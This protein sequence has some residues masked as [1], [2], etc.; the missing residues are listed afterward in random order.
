VGRRASAR[1]S[2]KS[3]ELKSRLNDLTG[4]EIFKDAELSDSE[5]TDE[6][7]EIKEAER[8][9]TVTPGEFTLPPLNIDTRPRRR[10]ISVEEKSKRDSVVKQKRAS[11]QENIEKQKKMSK[12]ERELKPTTDRKYNFLVTSQVLRR[13]AQ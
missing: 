3:H 11:K 9:V 10:R 5:Y 6:E 4:S 2:L 13:V 7:D 12:R 1:D 8:R